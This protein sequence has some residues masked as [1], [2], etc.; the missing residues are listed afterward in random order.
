MTALEKQLLAALKGLLKHSRSGKKDFVEAVVMA[1]EAID[2]A[3]AAQPVEGASGERLAAEMALSQ[4]LAARVDDLERQLATAP[5]AT[6][7]QPAAVQFLLNGDRFKVSTIRG[8]AG[9][10]GLPRT[11]TG[12]WVA[13]VDA[14]DGKHLESQQPAPAAQTRAVLQVLLRMQQDPRLAYLIGPGSEAW[15]LLTEAQA[16]ADG[17]EVEMFRRKFQKGL[18]Y[19]RVPRIGESS[20]MCD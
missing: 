19:Q 6:S 2:A 16:E 18:S 9:I 8:E 20:P 7:A 17:V 5:Q 4:Q 15:A 12:Q 14:T 11:M 10:Y 1:A 3:E 13:F